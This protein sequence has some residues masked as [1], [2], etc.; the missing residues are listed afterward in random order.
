MRVKGMGCGGFGP[1]VPPP[2]SNAPDNSFSITLLCR[3]CNVSQQQSHVHKPTMIIVNIIFWFRILVS[4]VWNCVNK[5]W[6]LRNN[7]WRV[8]RKFLSHPVNP[9]VLNEHGHL[10]ICRGTCYLGA[11]AGSALLSPILARLEC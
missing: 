3:I 11:K 4:W 10:G 5:D 1:S 7:W 9:V 8:M 6:L 2:P